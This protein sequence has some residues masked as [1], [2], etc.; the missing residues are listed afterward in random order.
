MKE[1]GKCLFLCNSKT[2]RFESMPSFK[3]QVS[4][5][6]QRNMCSCRIRRDEAVEWTEIWTLTDTRLCIQWKYIL[7]FHQRGLKEVTLIRWSGRSDRFRHL[8]S[9]NCSKLLPFMKGCHTAFRAEPVTW[10]EQTTDKTC[11][12]AGVTV[13]GLSPDRKNSSWWICSVVLSGRL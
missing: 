13:T 2:Q 9:E 3:Q 6:Y 12:C 8:S 1:V 10:V 4:L 5:V 11:Q 7:V